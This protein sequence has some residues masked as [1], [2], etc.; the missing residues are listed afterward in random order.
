MIEVTYLEFEENKGL[1]SIT[2]PPAFFVN[3]IELNDMFNL[4]Y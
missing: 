4:R 2:L 3:F 1:W